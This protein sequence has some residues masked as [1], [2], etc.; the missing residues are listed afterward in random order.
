MK[1]F[2]LTRLAGIQQVKRP[3]GL[4]E[5]YTRTCYLSISNY[6]I[7]ERKSKCNRTLP[8]RFSHAQR[9]LGFE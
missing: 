9:P 5:R 1:D 3:L 7:L 6:R 2:D 8:A 4:Q